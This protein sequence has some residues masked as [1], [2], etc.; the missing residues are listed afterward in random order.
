MEPKKEDYATLLR[1][2]LLNGLDPAVPPKSVRTV[3]Y[4]QAG[5]EVR[6]SIRFFKVQGVSASEGQ[7]RLKVWVR[8]THVASLSDRLA[9]GFDG[10]SLSYF[11]ALWRIWQQC[12]KILGGLY[13][14]NNTLADASVCC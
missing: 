11:F 8:M 4:S 3:D 2:H 12:G 6:M 13:L 9:Q 7:M 14:S 1:A 10:V 5:T